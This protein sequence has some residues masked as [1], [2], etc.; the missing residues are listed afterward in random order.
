MTCNFCKGGGVIYIMKPILRIISETTYETNDQRYSTSRTNETARGFLNES[1]PLN[2][3]LRLLQWL[4]RV[5]SVQLFYLLCRHHMA[6]VFLGLKSLKATG[7]SFSHFVFFWV[8]IFFCIIFL[9]QKSTI[10]SQFNWT[11]YTGYVLNYIHTPLLIPRLS[12]Q[13]N[14]VTFPNSRC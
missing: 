8:T 4:S 13:W 2:I 14:F 3:R 12:R 7:K 11:P 9:L 10:F 6:G 1:R 5:F